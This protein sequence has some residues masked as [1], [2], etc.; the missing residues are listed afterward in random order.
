M[1]SSEWL[2]YG[3]NESGVAVVASR[4]NWIGQQIPNIHH[5]NEYKHENKRLISQVIDLSE[6]GRTL[7]NLKDNAYTCESVEG[8]AKPCKRVTLQKNWNVHQRDQKCK[9]WF[10][11]KIFLKN[12]I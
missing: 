10:K 4:M 2:Q 7:N 8:V 9:Q 12:P 6:F 1:Q 3:F 11:R 5:L